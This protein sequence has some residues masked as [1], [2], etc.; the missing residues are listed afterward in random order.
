VYLGA[1]TGRS[2]ADRL[3][4]ALA[5]A[6]AFSFEQPDLSFPVKHCRFPATVSV[7]LNDLLGID[8]TITHRSFA[9]QTSAIV[10]VSP[11]YFAY[12]LVVSDSTS[13]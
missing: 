9:K 11:S 5:G 7:C 10:A 3:V 6:C 4:R 13:H 2:H 8:K 1:G 12:F